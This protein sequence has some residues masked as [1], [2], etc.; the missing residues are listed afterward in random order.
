MS[1]GKPVLGENTATTA[2]W[3]VVKTKVRAEQLAEENLC[4]QGYAAWLPRVTCE[5]RRRGKWQPNSE[6]LFPGY[7]FVELEAG[8]QN[9][10]PIRSTRGVSNLVSFAREPKAMPE[11]AVES[12][13]KLHD[14]LEDTAGVEL[15]EKGQKVRLVDGPFKGWEGVY[16]TR[17]ADERVII[18]LQVLGKQQPLIFARD[19]VIPA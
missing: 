1:H 11:G 7:V 5:R 19:D 16:D 3:Y 15:F 6:P 8:V 4:R 10:S 13:R 14:S 12:L 18:L 9:F 17:R 2:R